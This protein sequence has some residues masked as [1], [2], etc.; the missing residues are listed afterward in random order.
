MNQEQVDAFYI[1]GRKH[2]CGSKISYMKE[3]VEYGLKH[4]A[5]GEKFKNWLS[6][7]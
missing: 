1:T 3:F 6:K 5:K 4:Y 7:S 2:C